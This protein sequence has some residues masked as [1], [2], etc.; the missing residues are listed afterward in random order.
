MSGIEDETFWI[1]KGIEFENQ[2]AY[3]EGIKCFDNAL[4]INPKNP[5]SL[6]W[7]ARGLLQLH[8][9][10][11]AERYLR[12]VIEVDPK[13]DIGI[14]ASLIL[15]EIENQTNQELTDLVNLC[16]NDPDRGL[17]LLESLLEKNPGMKYDY[18]VGV[19]KT[20][21]YGSKGL[22]NMKEQ[23]YNVRALT[24]NQIR[25][26]FGITDI[27]LN[28]LEEGL[29]Q[30][31]E[32]EEKDPDGLSIF[33]KHTDGMV[34]LKMEYMAHVLERCRPGRVQKILGRTKLI[35]FGVERL[36]PHNQCTVTGSDL[37]VITD[38]FFTCEKTARSAAFRID[39]EDA[40]GRRF[41]VT[42]LFENVEQFNELGQ[43]SPL[44]GFITF[45]DDGT[46]RQGIPKYIEAIIE[47]KLDS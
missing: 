25:S 40:E 30:I 2:R 44:A 16:I 3:E 12:R 7:K 47:S 29:K 45:F 36:K 6:Y 8:Q 15:K 19:C 46:Y 37:S 27:H 20:F 9:V 26:E 32:M 11:E 35:Y 5:Y 14:D 39:G 22:M 18:L 42:M 38:T 13:S 31:R 10:T 34:G 28:Y 4:R 33:E 17:E 24:E 43:I 21:A 23:Q 41:I 1:E